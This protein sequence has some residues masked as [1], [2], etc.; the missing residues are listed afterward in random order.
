MDTSSYN[1][2][3]KGS[4][5]RVRANIDIKDYILAKKQITDIAYKYNF[6]SIYEYG[7]YKNNAGFH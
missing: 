7:S 2:G 4:R 6:L 5:I 3:K 1:G